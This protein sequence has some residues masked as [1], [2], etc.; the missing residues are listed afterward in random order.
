AQGQGGGGPAARPPRAPA[1]SA[2]PPCQQPACAPGLLPG[3]SLGLVGFPGVPLKFGNCVELQAS[4]AFNW[5]D[6]RCK[7]R[8]RYICQFGEGLPEAPLL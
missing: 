2:S 8:N 4:A 5:N 3:G 6:Q 1:I 7:T